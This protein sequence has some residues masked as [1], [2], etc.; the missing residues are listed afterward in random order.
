MDIFSND[1]K[2][3][4]IKVIKTKEMMIKNINFLL[5]K[6]IF[7]LICIKNNILNINNKYHL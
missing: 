6:N 5:I 3:R 4:I 2:D 7:D 1:K